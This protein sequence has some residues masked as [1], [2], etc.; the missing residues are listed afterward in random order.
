MRK[1][2][3]GL[4]LLLTAGAAALAQQILEERTVLNVEVPVRVFRGNTFIDNLT[5][6]YLPGQAVPEPGSLALLGLGLAGLGLSR[7]RKA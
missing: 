5:I 2:G 7:R 1:T 3:L 4:L 6:G